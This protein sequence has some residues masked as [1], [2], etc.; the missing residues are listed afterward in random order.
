MKAIH[1]SFHDGLLG[2][3]GSKP[4]LVCGLDLTLYLEEWAEWDFVI[5]EVGKRRE[6]GSL[7]EIR[8]DVTI[9]LDGD[10][11]MVLWHGLLSDAL[12]AKLFVTACDILAQGY[13]NYIQS[14]FEG[15]ICMHLKDVRTLRKMKSR[16]NIG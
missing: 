3:S 15:H 12:F 4:G 10:V 13:N 2:E 16:S 6:L 14:I 1:T 7:S 5:Q 11:V 9:V 8:L